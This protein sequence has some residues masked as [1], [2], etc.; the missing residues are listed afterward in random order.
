M[1]LLQ[2]T[3]NLMGASKGARA[4]APARAAARAAPRRAAGASHVARAGPAVAEPNVALEGFKTS[5]RDAYFT[6]RHE[7]VQNYFPSALGVEDFMSRVEI[8]LSAFG[9]N[10]N[11]SI[12]ERLRQRRGTKHFG[13]L[14]AATHT[15]HAYAHWPW[16]LPCFCANCTDYSA[17]A[18][19]RIGWAAGLDGVARRA[20]PRRAARSACVG[21]GGGVASRRRRCLVP[22]PSRSRAT[23]VIYCTEC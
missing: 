17:L 21:F 13:A 3:Q 10:G 16:D 5:N 20:A 9:F 6:R 18:A 1:A 4:A 19:L 11:N 8:A 23:T 14:R 15:R 7:I 2:R 22:S 12:G